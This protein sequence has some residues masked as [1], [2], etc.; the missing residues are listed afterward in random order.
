MDAIL[1][2]EVRRDLGGVGTET[3]EITGDGE[4]ITEQVSIQ[5]CNPLLKKLTILPRNPDK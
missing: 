4:F 3:Y 2:I 5:L 1:M